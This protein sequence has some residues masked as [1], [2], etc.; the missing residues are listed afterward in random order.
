[1]AHHAAAMDRQTEGSPAPGRVA[2]DPPAEA[3]QPLLPYARSFLV[4][5]TSD[6]DPA[7]KRVAGRIEHLQTGRQSR[8]ASLAALRACI[9]MVLGSADGPPPRAS[10]AKPA[11]ADGTRPRRTRVPAKRAARRRRPRGKRR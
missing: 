9:A 1:M 5:F 10:S 8:F 4:Q 11:S 6:T 2:A 7:L 3:A